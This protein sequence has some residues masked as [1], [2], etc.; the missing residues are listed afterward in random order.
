[1]QKDYA[2]PAIIT[3]SGTIPTLRHQGK[4]GLKAIGNIGEN[5]ESINNC[6]LFNIN[7]YK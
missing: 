6:I 2:N 5:T 4:D 1:M 3:S 7:L